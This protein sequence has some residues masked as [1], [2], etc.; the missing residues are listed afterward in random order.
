MKKN[1]APKY[2]TEATFKKESARVNQRF[3]GIDHQ[4]DSLDS[5]MRR[6]AVAVVQNTEDI[7]EIK[8]EMQG[9]VTMREDVQ[10]ILRHVQ[11][12]ASKYEET[13]R[14]RK[15]HL[16]QL[17]DFRPLLDDHEKRLIVLEAPK[18]R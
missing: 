1:L 13:E 12:I 2:V 3:D 7:K 14:T 18:N 4:F 17:M 15:I 6:M 16:E 9:N 5:T 11:D 8:K 10:A